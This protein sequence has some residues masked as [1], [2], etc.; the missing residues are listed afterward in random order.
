LIGKLKG[1]TLLSGRQCGKG[2]VH[3]YPNG[4]PAAFTAATAIELRR[5][6]IPA[7]TWVRQDPKGVVT[8]CAFP[9][10]TEIQ[11]HLCRGTGGPKGVSTAFYPSGALK[12]Y[13]LSKD[14][15]IQGIPCQA[16]LF[17]QFIELREN[18]EL[19][20]CMLSTDF[21]RDGQHWKKGIRIQLETNGSIRH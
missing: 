2:W 8:I 11:G 6:T 18:G 7:G 4:V 16:G 12:Q 15:I 5:F 19:M 20:G 21:E 13:L 3:L 10:N 1:D 9:G 14:T 17:S